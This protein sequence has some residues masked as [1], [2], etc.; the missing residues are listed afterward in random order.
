MSDSDKTLDKSDLLELYKIT[1]EDLQHRFRQHQ[2]RVAFYSSICT[3]TIAATVAGS[4]KA[5][6]EFSLLMLL[7]GPVVIF[8]L[9]HF[10][11]LATRNLYRACFE[12]LALKAKLQVQLGMTKCVLGVDA[13]YWASE[14]LLTSRMIEGASGFS[15]SDDFVD[16]FSREGFQ[17]SV[18]YLF[19][20]FQLAA[21]L[22]LLVLFYELG[23]LPLPIAESS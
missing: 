20:L 13:E 2:A 10:A 4:L 17:K 16:H 12:T 5:E 15:V 14:H 7:C 8:I 18:D 6:G 3:A 22:I 1:S 11:R 19:L 23:W 9:A 21:A